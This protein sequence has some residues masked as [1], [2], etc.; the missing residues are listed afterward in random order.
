MAEAGAAAK[1]TVPDAALS[2]GLPYL[3]LYSDL[4]AVA[5][6]GLR[7]PRPSRAGGDNLALLRLASSIHNLAS[8]P[9]LS[10]I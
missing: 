2:H 8:S 9:A 3:L 5:G 4:T 1:G 6:E 7:M 10:S